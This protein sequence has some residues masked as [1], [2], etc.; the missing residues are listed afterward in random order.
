MERERDQAH[1]GGPRYS[2]FVPALLIVIALILM[3]GFQMIQLTREHELLN[4][5]LEAQTGPLAES[6]KVREQLQSVV[7]STQALAQS[8]NQNAARIIDQ[9]EK[10]G[11]KINTEEN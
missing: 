6:Q 5:R 4:S 11:M 10:A 1:S 9:L 2:M 3:T 7:T 8:G